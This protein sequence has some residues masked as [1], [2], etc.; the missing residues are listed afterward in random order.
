MTLF[1]S[2]S[3]KLLVGCLAAAGLALAASP[4]A[5]MLYVIKFTTASQQ[6]QIY[7]TAPDW[8]T[9]G[10]LPGQITGISVINSVVTT[11]GHNFVDNGIPQR[12]TSIVPVGGFTNTFHQTNDNQLLSFVN[13]LNTT[14][15]SS[16][17]D[18]TWFDQG[19]FAVQL[20]DHT[21]VDLFYRPAV[22]HVPGAFTVQS[23]DI[24]HHRITASGTAIL[25]VPAPG[26]AAGFVGLLGLALGAA[27][28]R[29]RERFAR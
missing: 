21:I 12:V 23:F 16:N 20:M 7:F 19:G 3:K 26:L 2:R 28:L 22:G 6:G 25:S 17:L 11:T 24:N 10:A 1:A 27:G 15:A 9:A 13:N 29:L 5:A 18:S 8:T 14:P 4:A